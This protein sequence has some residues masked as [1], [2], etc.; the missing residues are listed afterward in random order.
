LL[1]NIPL[2]K[3]KIPPIIGYILTGIIIS[4]VFEIDKETIEHLAEFGI[5][6]LMFLIG[7]E[8][9]PEKLKSM[10]KEVFLY[11]IL[12]MLIVG[13]IFGFISFY[14]F[15][16][17]LQ[18]SLIIGS[19]FALSSTAIV[20]KLLNE[21]NEISKSFGRNSLGILLFQDIAVIPILL[22]IAII[23]NKDVSLSQ[24]LTETTIG[25][26]GL[27][28]MIYFFGKYIAP[29]ILKHAAKTKS[30]E[31]FLSTMLLI[32][33]SAAEIAHFFGL[34]YTLGAFLGGMIISET[35][36]K[37]QIEADLSPFRDLLLALFFI[38]VGLSVNLEFALNHLFE[39]LLMAF[40]FMALKTL[41]IFIILQ[42][43]TKKRVALKTAFAL[44][45]VGEFAFVILALLSSN[46]LI[47]PELDQEFILS[48][49][50][51][52]IA[53]PFIIKYLHN[54]VEIFDKNIDIEVEFKPANLG[55]H[56]V[57]IGYNNIGKKIAKKLNKLSQ[58]YI[59]IDK[60]IEN[61]KEG[62]KRGDNIILGNAGNRRILDALN[63]KEASTVIITT[64]HEEDIHIITENILAINPHMRIIVITDEMS[65]EYEY[66]KE[67]RIIRV[68]KSK[69]IAK[70]IIKLFLKLKEEH[71]SN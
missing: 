1:F 22:A 15:D 20:L 42:F 64:Q 41:I 25:F 46:N 50:I 38:S 17:E 12:E 26:I 48:I 21:R 45:Q 34:S 49:V 18:I 10:K 9:S 16:I 39:V 23:T 37:H 19:A 58:T 6:F 44:S 14:I 62:I 67:H 56:T 28:I 68:D 71:G 59:I 52:M 54:I 30:D 65:S 60:Q 4:S 27:A 40:S 63:I 70:K 33:L 31:I 13:L 69:E 7:I 5:I 61:V 32:V 8:F 47:N 24:L 35:P 43:F 66:Y 57:I 51:S 36:Y 11:G 29:F 53:T 2:S 3:L 55:G